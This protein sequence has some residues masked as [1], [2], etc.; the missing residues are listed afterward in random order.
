MITHQHYSFFEAWRKISV[1]SNSNQLEFTLLTLKLYCI[2]IMYL[3]DGLCN[4]DDIYCVHTVVRN[5][6]E[7]DRH[8]P[9]RKI[10][11]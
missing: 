9:D 6:H 2:C 5:E 3:L 7:E 11:Y 10:Q 4:E 8:I 1:I